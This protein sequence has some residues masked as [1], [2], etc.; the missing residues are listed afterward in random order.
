MMTTDD[1]NH[2]SIYIYIHKKV[3][4][5][6]VATEHMLESDDIKQDSVSVMSKTATVGARRS[7][8]D[9]LTCKNQVKG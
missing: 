9:A 1:D 5:S 4:L 2:K 8:R 7:Y 3:A 6:I